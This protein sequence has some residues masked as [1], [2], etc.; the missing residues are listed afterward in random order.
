LLLRLGK[1]KEV[2]MGE[3]RIREIYRALVYELLNWRDA[4]RE[5]KA[6]I[7]ARY[8]QWGVLRLHGTKVFAHQSRADYLA[9]LPGE[10][11]RRMLGRLYSQHDHARIQWQET[12]KEVERVAKAFWEVREFQRLPGVGPIAAHVFSAIIETPER[13]RDKHQL[14][15]YS[16]LG[17]T[18]RSSDNKPLG[19]QRLDRRGNRELKNL[20]YHA[21]RTACKSTTGPNAI[22]SFYQ[23]SK[24]RTTV[25][26]ARLNTQRKILEAMWQVWRRRQLFDPNKFFPTTATA[27]AQGAKATSASLG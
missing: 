10:E 23:A 3:D 4:Q 19:Y 11:E 20:S 27:S 26:H 7:K 12:L 14:W 13:F 15:K 1:L 9:Q 24:G 8:R 18:D 16:G 6:L 17:I 21:W 2:W 22:K 5:L 25:R